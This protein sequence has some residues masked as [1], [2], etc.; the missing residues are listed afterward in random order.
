[1]RGS[2]IFSSHIK[3]ESNSVSI[4]PGYALSAIAVD[5]D[6]NGNRG[7]NHDWLASFGQRV[8]SP[9][10]SITGKHNYISSSSLSAVDKSC[11]VGAAYP[12]LN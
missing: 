9:L 8:D 10:F 12:L 6:K 5:G 1:M 7:P 2:S 3:E 11:Y 4:V